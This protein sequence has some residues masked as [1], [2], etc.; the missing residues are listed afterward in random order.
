ST[1]SAR[2]GAES[3][4]SPFATPFHHPF[5]SPSRACGSPSGGSSMRRMSVLSVAMT[6]GVMSMVLA[7]YQAPPAQG[8]KV[9]DIQHGKDNLYVFLS[10][11]PANPAAFSG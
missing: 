4:A 9:I 6:V 2:P 5:D 8:P 1:R 7:G 10:S 11:S 3:S